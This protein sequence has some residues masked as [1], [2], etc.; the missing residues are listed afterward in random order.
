MLL[1]ESGSGSVSYTH[2]DRLHELHADFA[3]FFLVLL[4]L[5][6][7]LRLVGDLFFLEIEKLVYPRAEMLRRV[8]RAFRLRHGVHLARELDG[9]IVHRVEQAELFMV[10]VLKFLHREMC[11]RDRPW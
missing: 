7:F 4:L 10:G 11:I 9:G 3:A 6:L 2:L 5:R 1:K 8:L